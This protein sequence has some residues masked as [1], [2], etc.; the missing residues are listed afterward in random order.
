MTTLSDRAIDAMRS[1]SGHLFEGGI[2]FEESAGMSDEAVIAM[3]DSR[4]RDLD[5]QIGSYTRELQDRTVEAQRLGA[6]VTKLQA[7]RELLGN[8][9]L[10]NDDGSF[11]VDTE[12]DTNVMAELADRLGIADPAAFIARFDTTDDGKALTVSQFLSGMSVN[13]ESLIGMNHPNQLQQRSDSLGE[14]LRECNS[15]NEQIMVRLQSAMQQRTQA[16]TMCTNLLK[17]SDEAR[18]AVVGNLR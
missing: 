9:A 5:G 17:A 3:L 6:E 8:R 14:A 15:G 10:L 13:G 2:S 7:V 16:V 18:D 4:L 12:I 11:N 1:V